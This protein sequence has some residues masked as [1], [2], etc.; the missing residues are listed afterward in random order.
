MS[1]STWLSLCLYL[2]PYMCIFSI[3]A[4]VQGDLST[5]PNN[6]DHHPKVSRFSCYHDWIFLKIRQESLGLLFLA[7]TKLRS[8][9]DSM[10]L[11]REGRQDWQSR[12]CGGEVV[13][14]HPNSGRAWELSGET[15]KMLNTGSWCSAQRSAGKTH[16][17]WPQRAVEN[18][19]YLN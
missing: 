6:E 5:W 7:P 13:C 14:L 12:P 19:W 17:I 10:E 11:W 8:S 4:S 9:W 3:F 2:S 16:A 15:G 1:V 18:G